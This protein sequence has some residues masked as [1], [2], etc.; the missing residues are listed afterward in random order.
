MSEAE[1]TI[2]EELNSVQGAPVDLGG[3]YWPKPDA[4]TAAM[5]PSAT[6]NSILEGFAAG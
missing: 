6:L 3:Y 5:R 4:A 1:A 2:V